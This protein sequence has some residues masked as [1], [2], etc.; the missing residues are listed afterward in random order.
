MNDPGKWSDFG[1][2]KE[3]KETP[4]E[5]AI[6][7]GF[8]ESEGFLGDKDEI[9]KLIENESTK[10]IQT[11]NYTSYIIYIPYDKELPKKFRS[12]FLNI[13]KNYPEKINKNGRYEKDMLKWINI[14][15][16]PELYDTF[17]PWYKQILLNIINLDL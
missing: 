16:I 4:L 8:E 7:E 13:K 11:S 3:K 2:G 15:K 10:K 17:R 14:K 9:K 6:R 5:T 12:N 1:G